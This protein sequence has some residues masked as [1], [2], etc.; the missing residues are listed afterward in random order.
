[1]A[2]YAQTVIDI[3]LGEVGYLEKKSNTNLYSKTGNAGYAN[4]TKYGKEMHNLYPSVMDFPAA[5]CDCF[6]DWCFYKA[7]GITNAKALLGGD[8][9]DYTVA[10]ANLYKNKGAW[11]STPKAGDQIFFKNTTRICHTGLVYKVDSNRV[12]TVE[13]NTSGASGVVAN[14]GG[15]CKKSYPLGYAKIAGYGRPKY[16]T[17]SSNTP[18]KKLVTVKSIQHWANASYG[19][20]IAEDNEFGPETKTALVKIAQ[21]LIGVTEDGKF[22]AKSKA[23]WK[24]IKNGSTGELARVVQAMLIC[25]G[26][27]CGSYGADGDV[28]NGTVAAIKKFQTDNG[29]TVD[30]IVGK[31]TAYALFK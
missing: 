21:K 17:P 13:G 3:A 27:S 4:Y 30:G 28:G 2:N 20:T 15:V 24:T 9:N 5:W 26:Y 22:G 18:S 7:Y 25:I 14:G 1:M 29:L 10:S 12:Y 19:F 8:F 31:N 11:Y 6:V 23:A 16:D